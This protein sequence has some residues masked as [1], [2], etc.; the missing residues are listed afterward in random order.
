[1]TRQA[2]TMTLMSLMWHASQELL[3]FL[4]LLI[5]L[6]SNKRIVQ[7]FSN[8]HPTLRPY[9]HVDHQISNVKHSLAEQWLSLSTTSPY[10]RSNTE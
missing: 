8:S 10:M 6:N 3:K 1:M 2:K 4:W 7:L 9:Y 5:K